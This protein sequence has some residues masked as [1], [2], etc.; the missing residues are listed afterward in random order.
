MLFCILA[1]FLVAP[2][3]GVGDAA[4]RAG[5]ISFAVLA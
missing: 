5:A 2:G 4:D 1:P 3:L